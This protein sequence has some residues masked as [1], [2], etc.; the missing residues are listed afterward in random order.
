MLHL[1]FY[2][3]HWM[4]IYSLSHNYAIYVYDDNDIVPTMIIYLQWC[5]ICDMS[6]LLYSALLISRCH[7][8]PNN[9]WKTPLVRPLQRDMGVFRE[10]QVWLAFHIQRFFTA[11]NIVPY[12]TAVYRQSIVFYWSENLQS[13]MSSL[14]VSYLNLFSNWYKTS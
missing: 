5:C 1:F 9:S 3:L 10:F 11:C 8:S 7:F 4:L 13:L 6:L 12:Y 14:T 2:Y